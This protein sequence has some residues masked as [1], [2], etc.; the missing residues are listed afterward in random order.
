MNSGTYFLESTLETGGRKALEIGEVREIS[1]A[2]LRTENGNLYFRREVRVGDESDNQPHTLEI[3]RRIGDQFERELHTHT[4]W[5]ATYIKDDVVNIS[6]ENKA[7]TWLYYD[8]AGNP[9][10]MIDW[11]SHFPTAI[12]LYPLQRPDDGGRIFGADRVL[13]PRTHE[14][15]TFMND[16]IGLRSRARIYTEAIEKIA[17]KV[18]SDINIVS[19]GSGAAVPNIDASQ[20]IENKLDKAINWKFYDTDPNALKFAMALVKD[21]R[22]KKS[23]F[24]YGPAHDG[25]PIGQNYMRATTLT[26]ESV[27]VVDALGL[28]EYLDDNQ[29]KKFAEK[30]YRL[31]KPGG[32]MIISNMLPSRPQLEFNQRAVGWPGLSIRSDET[33]IDILASA[34]IDTSNVTATHSVDGVYVVLEIRKP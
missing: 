33:L 10:D 24:D 30:M 21:S 12:A 5:P 15:F 14:L 22:L 32:V 13:S 8:E 3:Y 11:A 19:L 28:W 23:S 27:D 4:E 34:S 16:G 18:D 1:S 17:E 25:Q 29:A 26:P 2:R 31:V 20:R 7:A 9:T 6:P